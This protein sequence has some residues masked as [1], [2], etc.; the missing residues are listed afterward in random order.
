MYCV[1][2]LTTKFNQEDINQIKALANAQQVKP[3][4]LVR[5]AVRVFIAENASAA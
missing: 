2:P 5:K 4:T 1:K 3:S